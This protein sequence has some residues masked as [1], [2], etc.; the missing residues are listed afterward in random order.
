MTLS[1][2]LRARLSAA[3]FG[4]ILSCSSWAQAADPTPAQIDLA[5]EV[6]IASGISRSFDN[7]VP[8]YM[9]QVTRTLTSTRPELA[10]DVDEALKT[11]RPEFEARKDELITTAAKIYASDL[12]EDELKAAKAFFTSP[13]G[14]KYVDSQPDMLN[15]LVAVV[16]AFSRVISTEMVDRVRTELKKKNIDF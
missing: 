14:K 12:S 3:A 11:V 5:R 1:F 13:A 10:K 15:K 2:S 16:Q 9:A 7:I 4:L 8:N 6:V